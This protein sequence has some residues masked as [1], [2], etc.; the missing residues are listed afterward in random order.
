MQPRP[1]SKTVVNFPSALSRYVILLFALSFFFF[2]SCLSKLKPLL[3]SWLWEAPK[4]AAS[5]RRRSSF[6]SICFQRTD[7][8][9]VWR[10]SISHRQ[11]GRKRR[12]WVGNYT[13]Q[14]WWPP[15]AG[16]GSKWNSRLCHS[17]FIFPL[18]FRP[19]AM[20]TDLEETVYIVLLI[21]RTII[22]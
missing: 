4:W 6:C 19:E 17:G 21:I 1:D 15:R 12:P 13:L 14:C 5:V 2:F 16:G 8:A 22:E 9:L 18:V 10:P 20:F 7:L 11:R 3:R